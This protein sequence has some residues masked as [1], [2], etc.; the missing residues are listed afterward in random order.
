[1]KSG[2]KTTEFWVALAPVFG[3]LFESL[4]GDGSNAFSLIICGTILAGLYIVSRTII[5]YK[6]I[7]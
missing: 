4:S 7:K 1:M 5:K 6:S 3:G 2:T